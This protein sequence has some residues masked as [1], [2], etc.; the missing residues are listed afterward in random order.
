MSRH[1]NPHALDPEPHPF[2]R[3]WQTAVAR[4][5]LA[6]AWLLLP[7]TNALNWLFRLGS[8]PT[9]ATIL[10]IQHAQRSVPKAHDR[11]PVQFEN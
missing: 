2:R 6:A 7:L 3:S 1:Y 11:H 8:R 5:K 10:E 9:A 4:V